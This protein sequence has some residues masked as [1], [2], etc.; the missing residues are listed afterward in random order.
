[1]KHGDATGVYICL[2]YSPTPA[3]NRRLIAAAS[4]VSSENESPL[5]PCVVLLVCVVHAETFKKKNVIKTPKN[6]KCLIM[7]KK[8]AVNLYI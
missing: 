8:K 5:V 2:V 4:L 3:S 6:L 1:M 7:E